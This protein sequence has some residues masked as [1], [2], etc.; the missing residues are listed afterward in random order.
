MSLERSAE[1]LRGAVE[2]HIN[3]CNLITSITS[4][5]ASHPARQGLMAAGKE[6][7]NQLDRYRAL[8]AEAEA[9]E[10]GV[11]TAANGTGTLTLS[12]TIAGL[13]EACAGVTV[14][15]VLE[16]TEADLAV[17]DELDMLAAHIQE[18]IG[19]DDARD[20]IRRIC[21]NRAEDLR[22]GVKRGPTAAE[23]IAAAE[24]ALEAWRD[25]MNT[26]GEWDDGCFYYAK[27]SASELEPRIERN[28]AATTLIAR[29]KEAH[30]A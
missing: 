26:H 4:A 2:S 18:Y 20:D 27:K 16:P 8:L 17:A 12:E 11:P 3:T 15:T 28:D 25:A 19:P 7:H 13:R 21:R 30:N 10:A 6:L 24:R 9:R 22:R 14:S 23:V 5:T 1:W 29:W